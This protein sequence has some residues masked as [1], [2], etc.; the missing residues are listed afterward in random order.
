MGVD[1]ADFIRVR[2]FPPKDETPTVVDSAAMEALEVLVE[3][4][5]AV[6]RGRLKILVY[7][8]AVAKSKHRIGR[9]LLVLLS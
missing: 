4:V 7:G 6:G 2:G 1:D 9:P 3:K 8:N 5:K